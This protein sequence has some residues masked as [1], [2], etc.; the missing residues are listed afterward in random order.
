MRT[1]TSNTCYY[2]NY[3]WNVCIK[4]FLAATSPRHIV[5]VIADREEGSYRMIHRDEA[6]DEVVI[7]NGDQV[8]TGKKRS[9]MVMMM[10]MMMV[11]VVKD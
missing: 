1:R 4:V 6:Q 7:V 2:G 5:P 11:V 10:M 9:V 3:L 8:E